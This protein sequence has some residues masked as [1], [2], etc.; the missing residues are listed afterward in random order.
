MRVQRSWN[1][2]WD[3]GERR[4]EAFSHQSLV[5]DGHIEVNSSIV[6]CQFIFLSRSAHEKRVPLAD[7]T[8]KPSGLGA[9]VRPVAC[10][11][12]ATTAGR[13]L[14]LD[15]FVL[16]SQVTDSGEGGGQ[17]RRRTKLKGRFPNGTLVYFHKPSA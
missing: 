6:R 12:G 13:G 15:F 1:K 11:S 5:S 3:S 8:V 7:N 4:Q 10:W 2:G 16:P 17:G 14:P 9:H